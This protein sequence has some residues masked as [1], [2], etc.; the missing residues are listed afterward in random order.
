[1]KIKVV[2]V[3]VVVSFFV[4]KWT[5]VADPKERLGDKDGFVEW[6]RYSC[7]F[8]LDSDAEELSSG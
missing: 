7:Q 1:M 6:G 8:S 2:F 3:R 4:E 5:L